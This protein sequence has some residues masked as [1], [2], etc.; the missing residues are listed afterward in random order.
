MVIVE[1]MLKERNWLKALQKV[2]DPMTWSSSAGSEKG[3]N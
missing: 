2:Y 1:L 3:M